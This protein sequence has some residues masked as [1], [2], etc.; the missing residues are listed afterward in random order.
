MKTAV[1]G[2]DPNWGRLV[3][4]AGRAGVA[5]D[6][7]RVRVRIGEVELFG[8]GRVFAHREP[9]AAKHLRGSEVAVEV[10]VGAGGTGTAHG[11]DL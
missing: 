8:D 2:S 11:V 5:F 3:A 1:H 6:L 7:G 9:A 4:V 10:D